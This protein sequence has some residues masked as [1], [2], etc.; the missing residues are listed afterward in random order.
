MTS[1]AYLPL[2]LQTTPLYGLPPPPSFYKKI[3]IPPSM[4]F[5]KYQPLPTINKGGVHSIC[6]QQSLI[7][8]FSLIQT[9]SRFSLKEVDNKT[10]TLVEIIVEESEY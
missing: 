5:Q 9:R 2:I 1:S 6:D 7:S 3:L 4:I 8:S 10:K